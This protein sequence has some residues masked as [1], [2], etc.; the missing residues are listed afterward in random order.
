MNDRVPRRVIIGVGNEFRGDDAAGI[1]AARCLRSSSLRGTDIVEHGGEGTSLLEL[2]RRY[3]EVVLIDAVNS[4]S[5][6]GTIHGIDGRTERL[7][8]SFRH[9]S[10]HAVGVA[11][12]IEL[13]LT[14]NMLPPTLVILGIEGTCFA[15]GT[16]CSGAVAAAVDTVVERCSTMEFRTLVSG[17]AVSG[18]REISNTNH[19]GAFTD[20]HAQA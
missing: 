18:H 14:L 17:T 13:G 1:V 16:G 19:P 7:P 10:S 15:P 8:R 9:A 6:A 20:R 3:D 12:A 11:E 4:G 5:P 2:M